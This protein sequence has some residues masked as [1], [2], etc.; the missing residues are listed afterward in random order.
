M[1]FASRNLGW[2]SIAAAPLLA[3]S[4]YYCAWR[5]GCYFDSKSGIGDVLASRPWST[6]AL[7]AV[8]ATWLALAAGVAIAARL[9][10][11]GTAASLLFFGVIVVPL[12]LLAIVVGE[13]SG[14]TGCGP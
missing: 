8:F 2:T 6:A 14:V 3:A 4:A 7:V 12:G 9:R 13:T 10:L 11:P 5:S 1:L